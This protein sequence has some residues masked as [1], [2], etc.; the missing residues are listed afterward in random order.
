[1]KLK[2]WRAREGLSLSA[3]GEMIGRSHVTVM[4]IERG[5]NPPDKDTIQAIYDATKG[6]VTL[7]DW[8]TEDGH[9]I[10]QDAS[11]SDAAE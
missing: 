10:P 6:E 5:D 4:R 8:F 7:L 9:P 2:D 1:M 3:F 11:M